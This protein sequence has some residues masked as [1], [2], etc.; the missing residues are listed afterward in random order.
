MR[1]KALHLIENFLKR[2]GE[3]NNAWFYN[4]EGVS[5]ILVHFL[6]VSD[7]TYTTDGRSLPI[8]PI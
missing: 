6:Q 8:H 3:Q 7:V 4:K 1:P 5:V 2:E